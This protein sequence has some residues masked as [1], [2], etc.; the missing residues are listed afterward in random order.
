MSVVGVDHFPA[1]SL[2]C[3]SDTNMFHCK[4]TS[5]PVGCEV[6]KFQVGFTRSVSKHT[7]CSV[8]SI[9][10]HLGRTT[11]QSSLGLLML[12]GLNTQAR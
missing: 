4:R 12:A 8:N 11:L 1:N 6:D 3:C 5:D 10:L 9:D 2:N 7:M